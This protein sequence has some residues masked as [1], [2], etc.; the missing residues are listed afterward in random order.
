MDLVLAAGDPGSRSRVLVVAVSAGSAGAAGLSGWL[1]VVLDDVAMTATVTVCCWL[2][3]TSESETDVL[4]PATDA[5]APTESALTSI[6]ILT[7]WF[8]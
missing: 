6:V 1:V 7:C 5:A 4:T 3:P 2:S 8:G